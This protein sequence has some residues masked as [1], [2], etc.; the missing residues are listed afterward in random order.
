MVEK[1]RLSCWKRMQLINYSYLFHTQWCKISKFEITF[2]LYLHD[3]IIPILK[4]SRNVY[5]SREGRRFRL[6]FEVLGT[7]IL[8]EG[9]G[10]V[11]WSTSYG[12]PLLLLPPLLLVL[13]ALRTQTWPFK[14]NNKSSLVPLFYKRRRKGEREG[15]KNKNEFE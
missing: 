13:L 5:K 9:N 6:Y 14:Q 8:W 15:R 10:I 12:V 4:L 7:M 2:K 1:I 3:K 11:I